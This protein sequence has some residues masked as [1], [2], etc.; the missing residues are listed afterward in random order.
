[1]T[2]PTIDERTSTT[3]GLTGLV[4]DANLDSRLDAV[5]A[6]RRCG[7]QVVGEAA[8]GAE[9]TFLAA[10]RRPSVI[11]MALEEPP[12]RGLATLEAL[13]RQNPDLPVVVYSSCDEPQFLRRAMRAGARD[14]LAKPLRADD[15]AEAVLS[16]L[17]H[18]EARGAALAGGEEV[19]GTGIIVTVAGAKGGIG[20]SSLAANLAVALRQLS[21]QEVALLD[22]D[23]QFGD[24]GV[25]FDLETSLDRCV[26]FLARDGVEVTR[27]SVADCLLTHSSGVKVLGVFPE[28]E[29]WRVV[30][31]S[32]VAKLADA[33]AETHEFVVVD[34]PGTINELVSVTMRAAD[35]V[36]LVTSLE[37]SSIKDTKTAVRILHS[38]EVDPARVRL[39]IN[40]STDAPSVTAQDVADATGLQVA[41]T[42]PHDRQLGRSVQRGVPIVLERP[43]AKF[44]R[45]VSEVAGAIAGVQPKGRARLLGFQNIGPMRRGGR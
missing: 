17:A 6:A 8:Y 29:D 39:I 22:A 35:I 30:R 18:D 28:P 26:S 34:T 23:V 33:L 42:I 15:L 45:A 14:F 19:T 12:M 21:G 44:S 37:M 36:L 1:M 13:Q 24:V 25:M 4:V 41:A 43:G 7:L 2:A 32:Q 38:L 9:A 11:L 31:P 20:K 40:D 10:E 3:D 5:T 16:V 27:Q